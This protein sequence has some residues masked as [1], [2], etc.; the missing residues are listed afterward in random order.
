M[1]GEGQ[2]IEFKET[3]GQIRPAVRT[4]AA[5]A[6]QPDGGII[7]F[8]INDNGTFNRRFQ[9]GKNT[10]TDVAQAVKANTLSMVTAQPL[11]PRIHQFDDPVMLVVEVDAALSADGPYLAY[12]ERW[13]RSGASTN[14]VNIDYK[15]LARAYNH[16][17]YD[18]DDHMGYRFCPTCGN[19]RLERGQYVDRQHDRLY[20]VIKCDACGWSDWSE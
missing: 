20:Y 9:I 6:S 8:G 17:L 3:T 5:F 4:A 14:R 7:I 19:D 18:E 16:H 2:N 12:G 10:Q 11:V 1:L 15:Q 13:R